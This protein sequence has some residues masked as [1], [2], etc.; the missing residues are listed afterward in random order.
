MNK[1]NTILSYIRKPAKKMIYD[2]FSKAYRVEGESINPFKQIR[3]NHKIKAD[4][5]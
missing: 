4:E 5:N 3:M 2:P 1:I